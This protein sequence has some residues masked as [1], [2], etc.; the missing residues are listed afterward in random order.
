MNYICELRNN[1]FSCCEG[2]Q[3]EC[4]QCEYYV[5]DGENYDNFSTKYESMYF[6]D[7]D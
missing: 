1:R 5:W 2:A 6:D 3:G 7:E 4:D